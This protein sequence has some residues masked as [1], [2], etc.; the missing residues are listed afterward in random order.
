MILF[1]NNSPGASTQDSVEVGIKR[2]AQAVLQ[3]LEVQN[4]DSIESEGDL[5][6]VE[7]QLPS[8]LKKLYTDNRQ[9]APVID[10]FKAY[11]RW[12]FTED[13]QL[14]KGYG[15]G[16]YLEN[17]RNPFYMPSFMY[18]AYADIIFYEQLNFEEYPELQNNFKTFLINYYEKY[19]PIRGTPDALAYILK[20]LFNC[21]VES[22]TS[23]AATITIISTLDKQ[24]FDLF[25]RL[26]CPYSFN[27]NFKPL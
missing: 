16:F 19:V 18:Q 26:A 5:I 8:W 17:I 27:V 2:I 21:S 23:T 20:S 14:G 3:T 13:A 25:K 24:Y 7:N 6:K 11:Y 12:L 15:L 1:F 9:N 4:V 22:I 10:F